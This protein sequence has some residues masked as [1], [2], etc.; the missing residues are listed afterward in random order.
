MSALLTNPFHIG[1]I[2]ADVDVAMAQYEAAGVRWHRP[3]SLTLD[4]LVRGEPQQIPVR[5]TYSVQGPVQLE[6]AS[7]PP[8]T[9][10]DVEE[11]GGLHHTGY[12]TA[13]LLGDIGRL[14][15]AGLDLVYTG[16][17]DDD[18]P[19]GFAFLLTPAGQRVELIDEAMLPLFENWYAGGDFG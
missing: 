15:T 17:G 9:L 2:V 12:W 16:R 4:L 11:Y 3:Q 5:F 8:G 14:T 19:A 18:S 10:W 7:G 1:M 6:V 13:D